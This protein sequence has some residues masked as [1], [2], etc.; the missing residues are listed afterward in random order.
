MSNLWDL[1]HLEPRTQSVLAGETMA[2]MFWNAVQARGPKVWMRQKELGL[3]RA[4][5]WQDTG[6]AVHELGHGLLALGFGVGATASRGI[7]VMGQFEIFAANS[8]RR[9]LVI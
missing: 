7:G 1:S 5:T 2:A 3:W 8:A 4:M 9:A 6:T